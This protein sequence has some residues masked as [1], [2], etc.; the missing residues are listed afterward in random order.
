MMRNSVAVF[1]IAHSVVLSCE[2]D[3]VRETGG[4]RSELVIGG[5]VA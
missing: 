4:E 1:L 3:D 5:G 2:V